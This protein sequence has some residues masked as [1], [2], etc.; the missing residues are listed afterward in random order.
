MHVS[1]LI[2]VSILSHYHPSKIKEETFIYLNTMNVFWKKL[3]LDELQLDW[4]FENSSLDDVSAEGTKV[5]WLGK[6]NQTH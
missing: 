6:K 2:H 3:S 1:N 5:S 4:P